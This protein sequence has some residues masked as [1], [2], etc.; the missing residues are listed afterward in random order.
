MFLSVRENMLIGCDQESDL[1]TVRIRECDN[2]KV[3]QF[4]MKLFFGVEF[5]SVSPE[6]LLVVKHTL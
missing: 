1:E 4:F 6:R 5:E 2:P 3:A